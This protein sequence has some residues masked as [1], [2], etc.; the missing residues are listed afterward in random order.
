[1]EE[2]VELDDGE[3]AEDAETLAMWARAAASLQPDGSR[4]PAHRCKVG[5]KKKITVEKISSFTFLFHPCFSCLV[6]YSCH[7]FWSLLSLFV[8]MLHI[9]AAV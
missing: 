7:I 8:I 2:Q 4:L 5:R 1:M 6:S 3:G 9:V